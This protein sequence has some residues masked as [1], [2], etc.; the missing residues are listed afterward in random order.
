[1]TN[2]NVS[3][4]KDTRSNLSSN[5]LLYNNSNSVSTHNIEGF[6]FMSINMIQRII[7][8]I[9]IIIIILSPCSPPSID[10]PITVILGEQ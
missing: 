4:N 8:I 5:T 6:R 1:M 3:K 9:I 2:Y 10:Y 7:I